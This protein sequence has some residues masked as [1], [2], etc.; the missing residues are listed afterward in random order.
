[1]VKLKTLEDIKKIKKANEIIARLYED[2]IPKYIKPGI[3][4]WEI[5][6]ICED[7]IK[8]QG[9]IP[10]TKGYDIGWPYP[11]YPAS[12]CISINEKV[13]H[14]I[15]SKTEILKEGDIL[16]LDTVTILDGYFGDAAK[17]FAV[18]NIDDRSRKLLEVTEKAREI[19]IEQ[20]RVGNR[21][22]DIGFAIQQYVEKF[23]FSV[24]RDFSGHGVGF[25]MHED[26]YVLN[27]GKANTGLKI[28]NGL[29][30]AIEPMVNMGT[31]KVKILK[32]MWTVVTQDKKRSAHFE[33]SVA[34]VDG[35]PLILSE[36]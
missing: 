24:V 11:P 34:I 26:P 5:D 2:I 20:A 9:A 30:I 27:Y 17:T 32:D 1:M 36:K 8:S 7:Y 3:S 23:G 13:V 6:A 31:F 19:G 16:S 33:H 29:V 22:G 12:T 28:E 25:A 15:P 4:T 35:K 21:I 14:G 18:G 10:G